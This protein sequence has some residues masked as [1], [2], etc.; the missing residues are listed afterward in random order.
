MHDV[1][2]VNNINRLCILSAEKG[3]Y[4]VPKIKKRT[5]NYSCDQMILFMISLIDFD[6]FRF[7]ENCNVDL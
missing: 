7:N 4:R 3:T 5:K 2:G 1:H 6:Y